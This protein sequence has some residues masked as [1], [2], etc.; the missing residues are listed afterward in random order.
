MVLNEQH[1]RKELAGYNEWRRQESQG[2]APEMGATS[3]GAGSRGPGKQKKTCASDWATAEKL[4]T[5]REDLWELRGIVDGTKLSLRDTRLDVLH[6]LFPSSSGIRFL[7]SLHDGQWYSPFP[8][9]LFFV[10]V[11]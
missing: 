6:P 8:Y 9:A 5:K 2:N 10:T 3:G 7:A 11:V 4:S 1:A